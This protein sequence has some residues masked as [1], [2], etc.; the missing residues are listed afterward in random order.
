MRQ[1]RSGGLPSRTDEGEKPGAIR[2]GAAVT[3]KGEETKTLKHV[4]KSI[5]WYGI[6]RVIFFR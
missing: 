3:S 4:F 6:P 5:S 2:D 1:A